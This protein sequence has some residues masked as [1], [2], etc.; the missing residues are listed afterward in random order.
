V[1]GARARLFASTVL[2]ACALT[3]PPFALDRDTVLP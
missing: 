2:A 1:S 3:L